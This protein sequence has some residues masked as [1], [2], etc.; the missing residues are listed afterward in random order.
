MSSSLQTYYAT[1]AQLIP[2]LLLALVVEFRAI[3][4]RRMTRGSWAPTVI[5][6]WLAGVGLFLCLV[7]IGFGI[8]VLGPLTRY[9][10]FGSAAGLTVPLLAALPHLHPGRDGDD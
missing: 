4:P 1:C 2:V 10:V 9:Y 6:V 5:A 8:E 3:A 7:A